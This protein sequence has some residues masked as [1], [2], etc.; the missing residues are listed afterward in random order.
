MFRYIIRYSVICAVRQDLRVPWA[1][2]IS[3]STLS[4]DAGQRLVLIV[5]LSCD[6]RLWSLPLL[7]RQHG[8]QKSE[9]GFHFCGIGHR[10]RDFLSKEF[11]I[12]LA[13][14]VN[15]DFERS[16][17]GVHFASQRGIRRVGLAEKEHLQPLE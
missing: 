7:A 6:V 14:P 15:R 16:L 4:P 11:A 10:I 17:R 1:G 2:H 5:I 9:F 12:S 8:S 3:S 13:K